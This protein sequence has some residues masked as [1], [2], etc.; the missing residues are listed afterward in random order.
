MHLQKVSKILSEVEENSNIKSNSTYS[1]T[2]F[3]KDDVIKS[4]ENYCQKFDLKLADKDCSLAIM[5]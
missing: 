3:S 1:K 5:Y 4:N 2:N